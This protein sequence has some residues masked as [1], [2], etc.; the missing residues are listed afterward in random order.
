[1]FT[2]HNATF[3]CAEFRDKLLAGKD[4]EHS[5]T[6]DPVYVVETEIESHAD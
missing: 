5:C 4:I 3:C 6:K 2:I 1:M